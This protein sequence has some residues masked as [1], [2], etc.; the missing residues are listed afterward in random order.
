VACLSATSADILER[1]GQCQAAVLADS[2]GE[3]QM[4]C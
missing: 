2:V 3:V 1:G 4:R